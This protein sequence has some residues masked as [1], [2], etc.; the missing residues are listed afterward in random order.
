DPE[1]TAPSHPHC[2]ARASRSPRFPAGNVVVEAIFSWPGIGEL[3]VNAAI[4]RD[5]PV[6]QFG[7]ITV[8]AAVIVINALTDIAYAYAD[9]RIRLGKG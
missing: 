3:L 2:A 4:T 8:A 1:L 5:Y 9:P 7:V 6:L